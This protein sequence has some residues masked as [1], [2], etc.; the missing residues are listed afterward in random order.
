MLTSNEATNECLSLLHCACHDGLTKIA[1]LLLQ[2]NANVNISGPSGV[3]PLRYACFT[4]H[5]DAADLLL[6]HNADVNMAL[7][8]AL[9]EGHTEIVDMLKQHAFH[10]PA[11][12]V[13]QQLPVQVSAE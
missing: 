8:L 4:G 9:L 12:S 3:T 11:G 7:D 1:Q 13:P 5:A 10:N 6:H 2:H